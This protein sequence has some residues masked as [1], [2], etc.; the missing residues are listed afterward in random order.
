MPPPLLLGFSRCV[1][2]GPLLELALA[3][4]DIAGNAIREWWC[5]VLCCLTM[6]PQP[7]KVQH[8]RLSGAA[9]ALR[10]AYSQAGRASVAFIDETFDVDPAHPRHF[11]VMAAVVVQ[12]EELDGLRAGLVD[13]A[14]SSYWHTSEALRTEAGRER[15]RE[16]LDYLGNPEGTERCV[17]R[18]H[19]EVAPSDSKGEEARAECLGE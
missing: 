5:L 9:E 10:L 3:C 7:S 15:T 16:M 1:A 2:R 13:L 11:Y 18:H 8:V 14:G 17:V 19:V 12:C 4:T 6:S